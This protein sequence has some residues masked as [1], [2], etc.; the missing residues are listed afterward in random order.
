MSDLLR[1]AAAGGG[2]LAVS[3]IAW[4]GRDLSAQEAQ[5]RVATPTPALSAIEGGSPSEE[6]VLRTLASESRTRDLPGEYVSGR[7]LVKF[8]EGAGTAQTQAA[9]LQRVA[10]H[11]KRTPE[12]A[13][14]DLV[15]I[16]AGSDPEAVASALAAQPD[17][18]YA[19]P[20]YRIYARFRPNDPEY[21]R[22]WNFAALDMEAAWDINRGATST[23]IVAVLDSGMAFRN[24]SFEYTA[25]AFRAQNRNYP[26]L[27]RVRIPFAAA[28]DL[29]SANRFVA[30]RDFIWND[31]DPVDLLGHGTHV[32]GTIGQLTDNGSG[33]AGM[34]FNV[35]LMPVKVISG[36]WDLI[37]NAPNSGTDAVLA[38]GIR[39]AVDNGARVL[40][41][42]LGR[43]NG[44]PAPAV[45]AALR[46]AVARGA[47]VAISAGN[48][49]EEGNPEERI[50]ELASRIDGVMS[51]A[52]VGRE[53]NR[54]PYSGVKPYVEIAAPG[55]DVRNGGTAGAIVQQSYDPTIGFATPF[56]NLPSVY[57]APR[58]DVFV[59]R[60]NQGTSM[61]A[62]HVSG[63]AALLM[64]QGIT[65]PS[66]IEAAIKRFATDRGPAG[67]DDEYGFGIVN[68]RATLRGLG[69]LK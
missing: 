11:G 57:R 13:D 61:A 69:L 2:L 7:V 50:A 1:W 10:A 52:A 21:S 53:L 66:A 32:A 36:Q 47:F 6:D 49:F 28:P 31:T 4:N 25:P 19:Q 56:D 45:E 63:L 54:A 67:R 27:G 60:P 5:R 62:P 16:D 65:N 3:A 22:Q 58:F 39:Y 24:V 38:Q 64:Q 20:D 41:M 68:P 15:E 8:R 34:A 43:S 55:G 26:A 23:V 35:R 18:E 14:F 51:V 9:T 44:G 46:D 33:G 48:D 59:Q 42:S 12:Y 29:T 17:V 40:N 37:F 30:P